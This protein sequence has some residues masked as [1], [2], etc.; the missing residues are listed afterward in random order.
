LQV[1]AGWGDLANAI[2]VLKAL[3]QEGD[4]NLVKLKM[5]PLLDPIRT[6]PEYHAIVAAL[7]FPP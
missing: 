2:Q 6:I 1:Y 3:Y 5:D 4:V 7:K